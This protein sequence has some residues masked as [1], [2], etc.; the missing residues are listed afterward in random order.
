MQ[1]LRERLTTSLDAEE[2]LQTN[3]N[4][5]RRECKSLKLKLSEKSMHNDEK[6]I[7]NISELLQEEQRKCSQLTDQFEK[8]QRSNE[9]QENVL[10]C[11]RTEKKTLNEQLEILQEENE[12]LI[13]S[14]EFSEST[15]EQLKSE[16]TRAK[17]EVKLKESECDWL[18]KK[19][20][21][22]NEA[23]VVKDSQMADYEELKNLRREIGDTREL[24]V[25]AKYNF[26]FRIKCL[27]QLTL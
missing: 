23:I 21:T 10:K 14:I 26:F 27:R 19:V 16:L 22:L 17:G 25:S 15:I 7:P 1:Q 2:Q 12:R 3:L 18:K 8:L 4:A 11:V 9:E 5:A 13:S 20:K 24:V 6:Q